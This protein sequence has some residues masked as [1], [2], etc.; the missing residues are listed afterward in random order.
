MDFYAIKLVHSMHFK[1][2]NNIK[3]LSNGLNNNHL[4][5][6]INNQEQDKT[7]KWMS[8]ANK[9]HSKARKIHKIN[10]NILEILRNQT[11]TVPLKRS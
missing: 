6:I 3:P 2:F 7:N 9:E 8:K 5:Q 10:K 1:A 11:L 4:S